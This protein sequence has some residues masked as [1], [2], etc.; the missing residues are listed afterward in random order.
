M[1][2]FLV[3]QDPTLIEE[4]DGV[5]THRPI[6]LEGL[7]YLDDKKIVEGADVP[8]AEQLLGM[9]IDDI[10]AAIDNCLAGSRPDG[11]R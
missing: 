1:L 9:S 11:C 6:R 8:L 10:R 5:P 4:F 3:P 7:A 2:L